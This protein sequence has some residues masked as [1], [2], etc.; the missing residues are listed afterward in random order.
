MDEKRTVFYKDFGACGD[1]VTDD[2]GAIKRCHEYAN[3]RGLSVKADEGKTYYIGDTFGEV[4]SIRTDTDLT[5]AT[6]FIDDKAVPVESEGRNAHIFTLDSSFPDWRKVYEEDSDIVKRF[7]SGFSKDIKNLGFE[8]GHKSIVYFYDKNNF[9]YNRF[10]TNGSV[11]PPPQSE[12]CVTDEVGNIIEDTGFLLDFSGVTRIETF[13]LD[14]EPITVKGG[15]F[16]TNANDAPP[17]YTS[18]KRGFLVHRS[19]ATLRDFEHKVIGEGEHGAPCSGFVKFIYTTNLLC[20]NLILQAHKTYCD[21]YPDGK[22][23]SRM[24]SYDISGE[25]SHNATFRSCTQSNFFKTDGSG[26][27]WGQTEYWGIMGS[28]YCKNITF[29]K[30]MLSRFD[31]HSGIRN[32][33]IRD[34]AINN[35]HLI[36]GGT[37]LIERTTSYAG[38][39]SFIYLRGDYGSTWRGEIILK[40]CVY[41]T[42]KPDVY[43]A[44]AR[45]H[46]RKVF[47]GDVTHR[48]DFVIDNLR[49]EGEYDK[50]YVYNGPITEGLPIADEVFPDGTVNENPVDLRSHVTVRNN[51]EGYNFLPANDEYVAG[52][53]TI[54][55]EE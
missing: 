54:E 36:G 15:T 39:D 47:G 43:I 6:F 24:G 48:P 11:T 45:Y 41:K 17:E 32:V 55:Y 14:D 28:N 7:S 26:R 37:A 33:T 21:F 40:D 5:G 13:R 20:E 38:T 53:V 1:G 44:V 42:R 29:D 35:I 30:C 16:I 10:G 19:N 2:F 50:V 34:T 23:R 8:P 51:K 49:I 9:A 4:I 31:A 25:N 18:Y 12:F 52:F 27:P 22:I 46:N 3:E